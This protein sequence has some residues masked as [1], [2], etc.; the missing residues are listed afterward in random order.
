MES[1]L[2]IYNIDIR[3]NKFNIIGKMNDDLTM[4]KSFGGA[5]ASP[6][7]QTMNND[8]RKLGFAFNNER[9]G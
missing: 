3:Y 8:S 2:F 5:R 9:G 7:T 1:I 6:F 4:T